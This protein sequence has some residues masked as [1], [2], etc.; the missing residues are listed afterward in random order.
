MQPVV[1]VAEMRALERATIEELGLPGIVLMD[2]A[3][4]ATA[5]AVA[6]VAPVG[7][8][9]VV[10]GPGNNG[11]DGYVVARVLAEAG[12]DVAT[13]LAAP[14]DAIAGDAATELAVLERA[15][16]VVLPC[17]T[18]ADLEAASGVL[19][20]AAVVVDAVFGLG[21]TREVTG[22]YAAV[23]AAI[24]R[25]PG[26]V[27]AVD[28]PSGIETDTGRVLGVAV[29]A[30]VTVTFGA[31]KI[32]LVTA[33]GFVHAGAVEVADVGIPR[34]LVDASAVGAGLWDATDAGRVAP[35]PHPTEHKGTRGH[36]V[37][38][39]GA[40]GTR[41]AGRLAA[42]GALR[43]GAGLC[44]LA[45]PADANGELAAPDAVMTAVVDDAA[46]VA[47]AI[48]GKAAV[49]VGP[50]MGRDDRA[51]ARLDAVLA[52]GVPAVVDADALFLLTDRLDAVVAAAGPVILTP[53][54][55]EAARLL[56]GTVADVARD[57]LA[58]ARALAAR[59]RAVVVLKGARTVVCDGT[60]GDEFCTI[61]PTGGPALATGG[62]GDVLAGVIGGLVAQGVAPGDAAR[63]GVWVH[64]RAGEALAAVLGA[65]GA[66][67]SDL[68][69]A[70]AREIAAVQDPPAQAARRIP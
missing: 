21:Q 56:G 30:D 14:R 22:H 67:A 49:V 25:A 46:S 65:R 8:V 34:R 68:P 69:E 51:R 52:A 40:P 55:K 1:T 36:V 48:A 27:V 50:G 13:L 12:R 47:A 20:E 9:V 42:L 3:G 24:E 62:T 6:R 63:L 31:L 17:A 29:D 7:Q 64:G 54:P 45:A 39:A 5:A 10:C 43:A 53:H 11:G 33:P 35:R 57:R 4:R 37:V 59:S 28:Q 66:I 58:V 41:G 19:A 15:G 32:G 26:V 44:T 61:N 16:G 60:L 23:I 2:T 18:A 38:V 70:V